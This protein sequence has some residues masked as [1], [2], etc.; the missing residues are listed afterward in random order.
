MNE[1]EFNRLKERKF[2][3]LQECFGS[4]FTE[5]DVC[6]S[7]Q[8][9]DFGMRSKNP[10]NNVRYYRSDKDDSTFSIPQKVEESFSLTPEDVTKLYPRQFM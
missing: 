2:D 10:L 4:E 6:L 7:F 1:E 3:V 9:L 5:D 8:S